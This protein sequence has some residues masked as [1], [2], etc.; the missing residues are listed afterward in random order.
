MI[1]A[2]TGLRVPVAN[3]HYASDGRLNARQAR[4]AKHACRHARKHTPAVNH[5]HVWM[6]VTTSVTSSDKARAPGKCAKQSGVNHNRI[7]VIIITSHLL[8]FRWDKP[9]ADIKSESRRHSNYLNVSLTAASGTLGR[10]SHFCCISSFEGWLRH[11]VID[12]LA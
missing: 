7:I 3:R 2:I 9:L 12:V 1:A 6:I 10:C 11:D 8:K 5:F 4:N